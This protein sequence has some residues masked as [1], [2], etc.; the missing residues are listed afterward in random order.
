MTTLRQNHNLITLSKL[1]SILSK[2]TLFKTKIHKDYL[3]STSC[4]NYLWYFFPIGLGWKYA[5]G[6]L[7]EVIVLKSVVD[8]TSMKV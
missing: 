5:V 3:N 8:I 1:L 2:I 7:R 4:Q 6:N